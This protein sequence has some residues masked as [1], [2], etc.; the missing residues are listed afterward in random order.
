MGGSATVGMEDQLHSLSLHHQP[1]PPLTTDVP[2]I[3][4]YNHCIRPLLD[5]V[6]KLR[7]LSITTEGIQLPTIVV[8]GDQSSG[9]SSVL[10][11]LAAIHLPRG[12][13]ICTRVPLVMKLQHHTS[14]QP[15]L[16]LEFNNKVVETDEANVSDAISLATA[17][18]AGGG[19]GISDTALTL[20][21]KKQGVPDLT[22]V[23]L[24]GITR[25]PVQ[26]QPENIYDQI[27]DIIMKYITPDESIILNVLSATVD[28]ATCES[29]RMSQSVD[30]SG[31]RT[32][33]VVTKAD[34]APEGLLE[35]VTADDVNIGLGYVC[36]R[37]RIGEETYEEARREEEKLFDAHSLLCKL[38]KSIVGIPVLAQKLVHIQAASISRNLPTIVKN[39]NEKL[40]SNIAELNRIPKHIA[41]AAEALTTFMRIVG[42]A[43]ESLNKILLRGEFDEFPDDV[44][45]HCTAR[46]VEM[47]DR[48]SSE[49]HQCEENSQGRHC[50]REEIQLLQESRGIKLPNFLPRPV[51]LM[52]LQKKVEGIS[53]APVGF[54]EKVWSYVDGVVLSVLMLHCENYPQLQKYTALAGRK[55]LGKMKERS[56]KWVDE[57]MEMEKLTD[58]TCSPEYLSDWNKLMGQ[59]ESFMK[60]VSMN[61]GWSS[62]MMT[63]EG[64]GEIE[65]GELGDYSEETIRQAFDLK[66]RVRAYWKIVLRRMVDAMALHLQLCLRNM[67]N[68]EL[69]AEIVEEVMGRGGTG[70]IESMLEESP[71]AAAKRLKLNKSIELLKKSKEVL[72]TVVH[73]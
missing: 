59:L 12:Q 45:M 6:D 41:S 30:K 37:N 46:L 14:P 7:H 11:S 23:D 61:R 65:V 27:K 73:M 52:I 8:V 56:G 31:K 38:D 10:E 63:I 33:A 53:N 67:V 54:V 26:G 60:N 55:L 34:K 66:M 36:V 15:L 19:K 51:F 5:A 62:K 58:Y 49:L 50:L 16:L 47:Q 18:I 2:I 70:G 40:R 35:K 17:E 1:P 21:V 72:A 68:R 20:I 69:E 4:S 71:S 3:S 42:A 13:G 28:F 48:Y 9:K 22:M 24:P 32:L 25:V 44:D 43:K 29:I 39:I 64:F 57:M